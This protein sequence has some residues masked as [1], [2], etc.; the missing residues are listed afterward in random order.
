MPSKVNV[1]RSASVRKSSNGTPSAKVEVQAKASPNSEPIKVY[2][3]R[4]EEDGSPTKDASYIRLPAPVTPY[5]LR[6]SIEAG[7][8]ASKEGSLWT[9]FPRAESV[10]DRAQFSEHKLPTDTSKLFHVDLSITRAGVFEFYVEYTVDAEEKST[11]L[12]SR[13]DGKAERRQGKHGY[14]NV[15]PVLK[16]SPRQP[17]LDSEG[18][19][20]A[21]GERGLSISKELAVLSQDAIVL[22]TFVAK[23]AG[24]LSEWPSHLNM[25]R[26]AGY[27]MLHFPPLQVRGSSNSPYSIADQ[28]DFSHDL[29][30]KSIKTKEARH[31]EMRSWLSKIKSDWGI[32]SMTDVVW[33]HTANNSAWLYE[34]PDAAY[35]PFN[36]PHLTPAE[37][38]DRALLEFNAIL[39]DEGLPI[40]PQNASDVEAIMEGVKTRVLA[41]LKLW[42][43]YVL[44]VEG[45]KD[46]FVKAWRKRSAGLSRNGA[47][48]LFK[49]DGLTLE[50]AANCLEEHAL[51]GRMSLAARFVTKIDVEAAVQILEQIAGVASDEE[52]FMAFENALDKINA[53]LYALYDEDYSA[54]VENLGG[55]LRYSRIEASGP[56]LGRITKENPFFEPYFTRLD[57]KH[58]LTKKVDPKKLALAHNGWI[59]AADPLTDFA[60]AD[61]RVYLRREVI[62]WGDCVKLRYGKKPE[63]SPF[64][65]EHMEAYTAN[66]AAMFDGFRIDN[67]HSTPVHVGEYFLDVARRINPNLYVCA[68]LFTGSAEMDVHFVSR[69]GI[70]S[71]IREMENGHDPKEESRLLYRFGV[72]KPIGSMDEACLAKAGVIQTVSSGVPVPCTIIPLEGST[73]HALFMDLTHDNETPSLKRTPEDAITM[74]ALIAFSWSA[75]GSTKGF[76]DLYPSLLNVVT[77]KRK[78]AVQQKPEDSGIGEVKRFLNHLHTEMVHEGFTEGHVHQ[79]NDYIMFHRV[80]PQTHKGYLCL[81]HTA[82][83]SR[84]KGRG[85]IDPIRLDN[86]KVRFIM[87]KSLEITSRESP[88]DDKVLKG[89]PS[90]LL[91]VVPP[92]L[93]EG[94]EGGKTY[95]EIDIP[96]YF[97]PGSIMVFST[98]IEGLG[99]EIDALCTSGAEKAVAGLGLVD[100]NVLLYRADGEEKDVT[101]G[102]DGVY[103]IPQFGKLVYCGLEGW[104]G[105]L[106][107]VIKHNDLGHPICAHLREGTWALDYVH[108]R[109]ERQLHTFPHLAAPAAWMKER[110]DAIKEHVPSF[111]RP[112]YFAMVINS[113]YN[114]ARARALEQMSPFV[115]KGDEFTKS[116]AMCAVQMNGLVKSASLWPDRDSA[117]MAAGL[118]FFAAS[119]ARM[120]G[121]DVFIS[122]RGLYLTTG[123]YEAAREHILAFGSTLKH[124]LIPNLLDS[125]RTP[126]YNCRDGPWFFAQNVQDYTKMVP[127]GQSILKDTVKLASSRILSVAELIQEILQEH[128][129]GIHFREDSQ[130]NDMRDEGFNIDIEVDWNTGIIFGGNRF[131]CGTWQDK[132]G[133]SA[134]AGNKGIPGS[135]R[136]GAAI[137]ITA[138]LKSALSWV[139]S[140]QASGQ[141]HTKGVQITQQG[142]KSFVTYKHWA[143]LIQSSFERCYYIPESPSDDKDYDINP[144]LV[145]RRG[146][147]KDVYGTPRDREWSD[148]QFRS[149]FPIAMSVAPEL[150]DSNHARSAIDMAHKILV[151]PLGMKTLDPSDWNYRPNY[152]QTE[153]DDPATSCGWNYHNGPEWVWLRG[154]FLRALLI[155]GLKDKTLSKAAIA[156]KIHGLLKDHRQHIVSSPWAGLPELTN[157]D[158]AFCKDSCH[159]QAWSAATILEALHLLA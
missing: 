104:M 29:F 38:L 146:I 55:R 25:A 35:N 102:N 2:E 76:D 73:P 36:S 141:W 26:D 122:L 111:L 82:F 118:P 58:P 147:Y 120:W 14:F 114:A 95:T 45:Q 22:Q 112:K 89:L 16:I 12:F 152:D 85:H 65:W 136:D 157:A 42:E 145:N 75:I 51:R 91:D 66:L 154:F 125:G 96:E 8:Y 6:F 40:D 119:W 64:L 74:G 87:G 62:A 131:N 100:L 123:M 18:R 101:G 126:R 46:M 107:S 9:N 33:N 28:N 110:F 37:E 44:D 153:T 103:E 86:T 137:E 15:D 34:Q 79:E 142:K 61:S 129:N 50:S 135:P 121:R 4:L 69:L 98:L 149:N 21:T 99:K 144:S 20:I 31:K 19:P 72:N 49:I 52:V 39:G 83:T 56:K 80:H 124:G 10:F 88:A 139:D 78:Y 156:H 68:E 127:G 116:L 108:S 128:A 151:G 11:S 30:N 5:V 57:P 47:S 148:Y 27:N 3:L 54:I 140:L 109:L 150:F 93:K 158:G 106:R 133:S 105:P 159:T 1:K 71:L 84:G 143:D 132:N 13:K 24:P 43:Y 115:Q 23:W 60:S 81:A 48:D 63:D 94:H 32:L 7:G 92:L 97:P 17:I 90:R 130:D 113:A 117:S 53:G 77:E 59:W 134:R 155:F 41:P 138:L 70:N 67:C